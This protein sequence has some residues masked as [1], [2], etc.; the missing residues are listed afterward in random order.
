[1]CVCVAPRISLPEGRETP[2]GPRAKAGKKH[3]LHSLSAEEGVR[4][5]EA[6]AECL[7]GLVTRT[8]SPGHECVPTVP[9]RL[10]GDATAQPCALAPRYAT[11]RLLP[12]LPL[13]PSP[14]RPA[15]TQSGQRA[16]ACR[17]ASPGTTPPLR[18]EGGGRAAARPSS[19]RQR[20]GLPGPAVVGGFS[21]WSRVRWGVRR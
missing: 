19:T 14:L 10:C 18:A 13:A 11:L 2:Q 6:L 9:T 15:V 4:R 21:E 12:C 8:Q 3:I 20:R 5:R 17:P 1:M 7:P 16:G